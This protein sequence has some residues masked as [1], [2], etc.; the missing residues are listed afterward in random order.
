[1]RDRHFLS[2]LGAVCALM[3]VTCRISA[4]QPSVAAPVAVDS[5]MLPYARPGQLVDVGGRHLNMVCSGTGSPTVVLGSGI[6]SW[7]VIWYMTQ[8]EIAKHTR[9]CAF[10]Q[11]SYGFSDA[12]P[13]PQIVPEVTE[14][15][16]TTVVRT[17]C[18]TG[19]DV[20]AWRA[21]GRHRVGAFDHA[22]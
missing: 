21:Q 2:A 18:G 22:G 10:D 19:T 15:L 4:A 7:S 14:H 16:Q 8:P 5:R 17:A 1:M 3:A 12:A 11:A 20:F 13:R 9:G 6:A